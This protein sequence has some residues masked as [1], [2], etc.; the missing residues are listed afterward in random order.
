MCNF[1]TC[2]NGNP[3]LQGKRATPCRMHS[4]PTTRQKKCIR[5]KNVSQKEEKWIYF[6]VYLLV[7]IVYGKVRW[8][9]RTERKNKKPAKENEGNKNERKRKELDTKVM[10]RKER[11]H[12]RRTLTER[13]L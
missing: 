1:C 10:N 7:R 11:W 2:E 3:S 6:A 4:L 9:L 13:A 5:E 12:G 8:I